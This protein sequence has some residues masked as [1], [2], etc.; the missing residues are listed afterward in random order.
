MTLNKDKRK[1]ICPHC[2]TIVCAIIPCGGDGR[3]VYR[4]HKDGSKRRCR[5]SRMIV[6]PDQYYKVAP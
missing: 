2:G 4:T 5:M 1:A 3:P 6:A